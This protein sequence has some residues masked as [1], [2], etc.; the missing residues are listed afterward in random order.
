MKR[1][2]PIIP[3]DAAERVSLIKKAIESKC[4]S[5]HVTD[6]GQHIQIS[7]HHELTGEEKKTLKSLGIPRHRH[8]ARIYKEDDEYQ[9]YIHRLMKKGLISP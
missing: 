1:E 6:E 2:A 9:H 3:E 5:L 8:G 7:W 4:R